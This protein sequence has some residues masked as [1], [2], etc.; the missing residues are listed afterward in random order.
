MPSV[1]LY[2]PAKFGGFDFPCMETIQ[3]QKG[4]SLVLRQLQW[5]KENAKDIRILDSGLVEPILEET[6]T[7]TPY[8]EVSL[9]RHL[10]E[11]LNYLDGKLAVKN[12]RY[13]QLQRERD[14]SIMQ[15]L[16]R[17]P[18]VTPGELKK[19]NLCRKWL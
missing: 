15:A 2:A 9:I 10:R 7:P 8:L 13:P 12:L 19:A 17:L 4:I 1:V 5:D 16:S 14:T 11:R 18:G 6:K 3:D